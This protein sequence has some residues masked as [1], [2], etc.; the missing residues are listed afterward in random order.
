M[1]II[2]IKNNDDDDDDDNNHLHHHHH[3]HHNCIERRSSR[4]V[5]I[6]SLRRELSPTR[7][8]KRPGR[9]RVQITCNTPSAYH[10]QPAVCH[11]VRRDSSA[12]K[13]DRAEIAFMLAL[14]YWLKQL[15]EEGGEETECP[16]KTPDDDLQKMPHSKVPPPLPPKNSSP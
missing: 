10:M 1:I 14:F 11:V 9:N 5:A 3:H 4:V 12:S 16:K 2:I 8:V 13:F 7:T 15:T 6:T